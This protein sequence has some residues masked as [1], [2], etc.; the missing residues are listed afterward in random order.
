MTSFSESEEAGTKRG[1]HS[2]APP[3][4]LNLEMHC[5]HVANPLPVANFYYYS[6]V[7][8]FLH[9]RIPT[10]T[11]VYSVVA[12]VVCLSRWVPPGYDQRVLLSV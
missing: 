2:R 8:A 4:D 7:V 6:V 5:H 11:I 10:S 12:V 1:C 3:S 9:I